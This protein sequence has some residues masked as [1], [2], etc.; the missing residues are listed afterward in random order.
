[1]RRFLTIAIGAALLVATP[2]AASAQSGPM[3]RPGAPQTSPGPDR[4]GQDRPG[5][6]RPDMH[7]NDYGR[8]DNGWGRRP[9]P[10]PKH[11]NRHGN[12]YQHVRACSARYRSY[13]PRT[14]TYQLRRGIYRRCRL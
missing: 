1:M 5:M 13:N 12:W 8:W 6:G 14:D 4:P 11:F 7:G 3:G 9:P 2:L 10:P